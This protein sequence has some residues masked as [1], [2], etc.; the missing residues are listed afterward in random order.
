MIARLRTAGDATSADILEI[1]LREEIGHVAA[2]SRWFAWCCEC[3]G[4]EPHPTFERLLATHLKGP[5]K[6]PFN[7]SARLAAGFTRDELERLGARVA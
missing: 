2:G 4:H 3:E 1:I 5:L 6:G 7:E